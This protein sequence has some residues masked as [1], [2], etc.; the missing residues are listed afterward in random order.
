LPALALIKHTCARVLE[1]QNQQPVA[2]TQAH[3]IAVL[4]SFVSV[5]VGLRCC[6]CV[7]L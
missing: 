4:A 7:C 2:L 3:L 6:L 1:L 5:S